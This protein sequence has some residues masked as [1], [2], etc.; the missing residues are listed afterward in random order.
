MSSKHLRPLIILHGGWG[1]LGGASFERQSSAWVSKD[2]AA[3]APRPMA[4]SPLEI[5]CLNMA[6]QYNI[7]LA[8][9]AELYINCKNS[10]QT[11][12][13]NYLY[14]VMGRSFII[15]RRYNISKTRTQKMLSKMRVFSVFQLFNWSGNKDK[16]FS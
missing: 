11:N 9:K 13:S 12:W 8:M 1:I 15:R 2:R 3:A 10:K 14:S 7:R 6:T 16:R 5:R 4:P